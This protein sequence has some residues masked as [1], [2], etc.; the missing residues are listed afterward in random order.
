MNILSILC[1]ENITAQMMSLMG[2]SSQH[3]KVSGALKRA[4][5]AEQGVRSSL[6]WVALKSPLDDAM[7]WLE[8]LSL[9]PPSTSILVGPLKFYLMMRAIYDYFFG[10]LSSKEMKVLSQMVSGLIDEGLIFSGTIVLVVL[11]YARLSIMYP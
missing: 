10:R 7:L 5:E 1:F 9:L 8:R 2:F 6:L 11:I 3:L 4:Q